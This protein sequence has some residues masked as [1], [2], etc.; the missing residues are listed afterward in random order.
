MKLT[1]T[2]FGCYTNQTFT[3]PDE[4]NILISGPS[5]R[6]K[7]TIVRALEFALFGTGNKIVSFGKKKCTVELTFKDLHIL[8]TK[9]PN[10][11][12]VNGTMEDAEGQ[13]FLSTM[14]PDRMFFLHQNNRNTFLSLPSVNK[15]EYLERLTFQHVDLPSLK[16]QLKDKCRTLELRLATLRGELDVCTQLTKTEVAPPPPCKTTLTL[17]ECDAVQQQ[18]TIDLQHLRAQQH[19][20]QTYICRRTEVDTQRSTLTSRLTQLE[21]EL[22]T[23]PED[24]DVQLDALNESRKQHERWIEYTRV[25]EDYLNQK[26]VYEE[27]IKNE[28]NQVETNLQECQ[29]MLDEYEDV[30]Y[31]KSHIRLYQR[32]HQLL[33]DLS[34]LAQDVDVNELKSRCEELRQQ[35][36]VT[37]KCP[38][39]SS[40]LCFKQELLEIVETVVTPSADTAT[41]ERELETCQTQLETVDTQHKQYLYV[42]S[43]LASLRPKLDTETTLDELE[44]DLKTVLHHQTL[45]DQY[46]RD[47]TNV[48]HRY[49]SLKRQLLNLKREYK[50]YEP[51]D[52]PTKPFD[53]TELESLRRDRAM[54]QRLVHHIQQTR[55]EISQ[56]TLP[57]PVKDVA[58]DILAC[59]EE[60][61]ELQDVRVYLQKQNLY[62]TYCTYKEQQARLEQEQQTMKTTLLDLARFKELVLKTE[63]ISFSNTIHTLNTNLQ[64]Y[65]DAFF[66]DDPLEVKVLLR[67]TSKTT[68]VE[69]TQVN[70]QVFYKNTEVDISTLSGGEYDRVVLAFA[71]ALTEMNTSPFIVLDECVSSLDQTTATTVCDFIREQCKGKLILLIAHQIVTGMFDQI[72]SL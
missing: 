4:G 49:R 65:L 67:K 9:G 47:K 60:L 35:L 29:M 30:T 59:E 51:I 52:E 28:L 14:F 1:L 44:T 43:K 57:P 25:R 54:R 21:E 6:G 24:L 38:S 10:R 64:T 41:L 36:Q 31:Y 71:L 50:F 46:Q 72:I 53:E 19:T 69:T 37:Y 13:H 48:E 23:Y 68:K 39:C 32:Y 17:E 27:S 2:N 63:A 45:R 7:T 15:L 56:L 40:T 11:L 58:D 3:L 22:S 8:R 55:D 42:Q 5:G 26:R 34:H 12:V 70:L 62:T 61:T 18:R 33:E 16:K 20:Y 66:P